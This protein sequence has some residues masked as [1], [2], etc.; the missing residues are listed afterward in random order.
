MSALTSVESTG[1]SNIR[2]LIAVPRGA[3]KVYIRKYLSSGDF[4]AV[5]I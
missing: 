4:G 3:I 5:G 1:H 2:A